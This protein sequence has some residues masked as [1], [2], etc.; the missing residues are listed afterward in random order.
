L[1][2]SFSSHFHFLPLPSPPPLSSST[3]SPFPHLLSS[4]LP[5]LFSSFLSWNVTTR[6]VVQW[7]LKGKCR[8]H[9]W[10][11]FFWTPL[12]KFK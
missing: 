3:S 6:L 1:L 7:P 4:S 2:L 10:I 12:V 9:E 11:Q 5:L 8:L